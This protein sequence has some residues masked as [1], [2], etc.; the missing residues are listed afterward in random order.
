MFKK[1]NSSK[2]TRP[3]FFKELKNEFGGQSENIILKFKQLCEKHPKEI[4][5]GMVTIIVISAILSFTVIMP[6][7][8]KRLEEEMHTSEI[9]ARKKN[10]EVARPLPGNNLGEVVDGIGKMKSLIMI[11][12]QVDA[13][14][15][16]KK[17]SAQDSNILRGL[18]D[19]VRQTQ[20]Y[21]NSK[22]KR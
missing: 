15:T 5:I 8:K 9:V 3:N 18:L 22:Y 20:M 7:E 10:L 11:R 6:M 14:L 16:K 4:F 12:R 21:L 13:I 17:L 2:E 19:S 1:I